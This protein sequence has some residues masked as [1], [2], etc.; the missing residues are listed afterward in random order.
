MSAAEF[1]KIAGN[2]APAPVGN[3]TPAIAPVKDKPNGDLMTKEESARGA[4]SIS[5][6]RTYA[7]SCGVFSV[8]VYLV[9][10]L[11][12]QATSVIQT[13]WLA[14]WSKDNDVQES[15]PNGPEWTVS[16]RIGIYGLLG[17]LFCITSF[18]QTVYA[19]VFCGIRSARILHQEMLANVVRLPQSWF[20]TTSMGRVLN[21]FAKDQ[22]TVDETIPRSFMSF[23]STVARVFAVLVVDTIATPLFLAFVL[24]LGYVYYS[25]SKYCG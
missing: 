9:V 21:R 14:N 15:G 16:W 1:N 17:L 25:V 10:L 24:P 18:V 8:V 3:G 2:V 6:Y 23:F 12:S 4:V 20:D 11:I 7:E 19:W 22:N 13:F 5:V